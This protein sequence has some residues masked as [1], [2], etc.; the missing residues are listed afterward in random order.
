MHPES[1]LFLQYE[2]MYQD[3]AAAIQKI[4]AFL[5]IP[6]TPEVLSKIVKNCSIKEMRETS[7]F[8]LNH[9]RQG[10]YGNWRG[11]FSVALSEFFD[12]VSR[13]N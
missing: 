6:C 8:G 11:T 12:D 10:G 3:N 1:H 4:A 2:D 7:N 13:S 5:N 9:L